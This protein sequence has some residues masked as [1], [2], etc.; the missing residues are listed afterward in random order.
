MAELEWGRKDGHFRWTHALSPGAR[1][2]SGQDF[3]GPGKAGGLEQRNG[4]WGKKEG[5]S[6][7]GLGVCRTWKASELGLGST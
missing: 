2:G 1:S 5:G 3:L 6:W 4:G 7:A